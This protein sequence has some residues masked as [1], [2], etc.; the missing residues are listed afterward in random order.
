MR[1]PL[2]RQQRD[3][4]GAAAGATLPDSSNLAAAH[5]GSTSGQT[6]GLVPSPQDLVRNIENLEP[7]FPTPAY[8]AETA[9]AY[10]RDCA[11]QLRTTVQRLGAPVGKYDW[12]VHNLQEIELLFD[13]ARTRTSFLSVSTGGGGLIPNI[14]LNPAEIPWWFAKIAGILGLGAIVD[15]FWDLLEGLAPELLKGLGAAI[16]AGDWKNAL[17]LFN[18]LL[19]TVCTKK[20]M[21]ALG[22]RVGEKQAAQVIGNIMAKSLPFIGWLIVA[23][24]IG[25]GI[26]ENKDKIFYRT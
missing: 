7:P 13:Q 9:L 11:Q 17:K 12:S 8:L 19:D 18:S 26:W 15:A 1:P 21:A 5:T 22:K 10:L 24:E 6:T 3:G 23:A 16:A 20:F 25:W 4:A 14:S 2:Y